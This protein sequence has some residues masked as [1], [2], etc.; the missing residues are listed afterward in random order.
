MSE[1]LSSDAEEYLSWLAVEKGRSRNTLVAY[2]H[3]LV[4]YEA[5]ATSEGLDTAQ[6]RPADLERYLD[7]LRA[8]GRNPDS[9]ARAT[10][11]LRGLYRFWVAEGVV[12]T[13][14]TGDVRSPKLP[15]RL[16][17]ALDEKVA[18]LHLAKVG[19]KLTKLNEK[20]A[21]YIGVSQTGPFKPDT[22]RY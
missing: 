19:A 13:D 12:T 8:Q 17:K 3:D 6:A 1:A 15:R 4:G 18:R 7:G 16:P 9:L 20:Q 11:S 21:S 14:P 22:Y 2:R 5:W 10:T